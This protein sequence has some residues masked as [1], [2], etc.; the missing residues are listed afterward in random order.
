MVSGRKHSVIFTS[1]PKCINRNG[2]FI[3][4][5]LK[6]SELSLEEFV[7]NEVME[8]NIRVHPA[9]FMRAGLTIIGDFLS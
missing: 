1:C 9:K 7:V 5:Y 6:L 8:S 4:I 2:E 3:P